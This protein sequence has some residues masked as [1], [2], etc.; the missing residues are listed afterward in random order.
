MLSL[1]FNIWTISIN[2]SHNRIELNISNI[3]NH[4]DFRTV[5]TFLG[6]DMKDPNNPMLQEEGKRADNADEI[7]KKLK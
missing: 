5:E 2:R 7:S 3:I 4:P 1:L 6:E